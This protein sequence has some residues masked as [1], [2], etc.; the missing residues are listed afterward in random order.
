MPRTHVAVVSLSRSKMINTF[1]Y[2]I[3][4][5]SQDFSVFTL[6]GP[7]VFSFLQ[8]Q[9]TADLKLLLDKSFTLASFLDPQGRVETYGWLLKE[10]DHYFFVVPQ[11]LELA[12]YE[13]LNRF[14]ISEDVT[15][16]EASQQVW[17]FI[18][19]VH[20]HKQTGF[21]GTL[22][23]DTATMVKSS[24]EEIPVIS[25]IDVETWRGLTGWPSFTATDFEKELINNSRLF[26]LS[27]S[28]S[29]GC[30]PGQETVSKI[31]TRRGAAYSPVLLECSKMMSPGPVSNFDKKIGTA[32]ACY[33]W[34][35]KYYLSATLL[36]DFRVLGLKVSVQINDVQE[37]MTVRYLPLI[38][39][40]PEEKAEE[41]YYSATEHF[42]RDDI[43]SAE[44][45][46]KLAI[47]INPSFAD[48]YEILGVILGREGRFGEAISY[49]EK[50]SQV[51][52]ASVLAHTNMSLYLMKL[53]KIE[54]AEDQK[55]KA[56]IKSFQK[57]GQEAK[58]KEQ[59]KLK[60]SE[61][62]SEWQKRESMFIQVLEIDAE[63]TLANFGLG[64]IA[65]EKKD[66]T[67]A[68]GHLEIVLKADPKYSVAYLGLG[69]AYLG[70]GLKDQAKSTWQEGIK[71]A[72]SKGDLMPANQMQFELEKI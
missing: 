34:L 32:F 26:D 38:Q 59:N 3:G 5:F 71:V 50:L 7:D 23:A 16:S 72:A 69:K 55:S 65:L 14:L 60:Q 2:D 31:A 17:T 9:S 52:P 62:E 57:F 64:T 45:E 11:A 6:T 20:A 39:G 33:E 12:T 25:S 46:L 27:V 53:G 24:P 43:Q 70:L 28:S 67:R 61:Q 41:L 8:N 35:G 40:S 51:D 10:D 68:R 13:R 29:K 37:T 4:Q 58:E 48:A 18:I 15:V 47:E 22:F 30:Y 44:K 54:E 42:K 36:R 49:M 63:D 56:T 66:W 1:R 19:G 21:K